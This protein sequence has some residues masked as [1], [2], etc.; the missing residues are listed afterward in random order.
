[1]SKRRDKET[2]R[3]WNE[4]FPTTHWTDILEVSSGDK[5]RRLLALEKLAL[6]YWKPVYYYLRCKGNGHEDAKDLTQ[7]FF[8]EVVMGRHLVEQA[9]REKGRFRTFILTALERYAV[10]AH[11]VERAKQRLPEGGLVRLEGLDS[12][13]SPSLLHYTT[14]GDA[15]DHGWALALLDQVLAQVAREC[16]E[17]GK[18]IHW[19]VFEAK[20]LQPILTNVERPPLIRLCEEYGIRNNITAS[21]MIVT[22]KR[23]F[24]SV[25]RRH[26]RYFVSSESEVEEEIRHLMKILRRRSAGS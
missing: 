16:H 22:V 24:Q 14:P 25:L 3:G 7:G 2:S 5:P 13:D 19:K 21:N 23:R 26:V 6:R 20:V 10:S 9:T 1:M 18:E 12:W 11:R 8:H 15:F 4:P 17:R